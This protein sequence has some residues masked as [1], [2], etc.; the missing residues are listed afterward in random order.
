MHDAARPAG[1]HPPHGGRCRLQGCAA[2]HRASAR[3]GA[4]CEGPQGRTRRTMAR[5]SG[6]HRAAPL[7]RPDRPRSHQ[8]MPPLATR[9]CPAWATAWFPIPFRLRSPRRNAPAGAPAPRHAPPAPCV[10]PE[11]PGR[12]WRRRRRPGGTTRCRRRALRGHGPRGGRRAGRGPRPGCNSAGSL[13]RT[14]ARECFGRQEG[15]NRHDVRRRSA[16]LHPR[17]R[18]LPR[19][20]QHALAGTAYTPRPRRAGRRTPGSG[21]TPGA[22]KTARRCSARCGDAWQ[23]CSPAPPAADIRR[24]ALGR[25]RFP[26]RAVGGAGL[27]RWGDA[28]EAAA[29]LLEGGI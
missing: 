21:Q 19:R 10:A 5:T 29:H 3:L 4:P 23:E 11:L 20:R 7:D 6:E 14:P 1:T 16:V 28:E 2:A 22:E 24:R 27:G 12:A 25:G 15:Q 9:A 17:G 18:R 8:S 26:G 13:P